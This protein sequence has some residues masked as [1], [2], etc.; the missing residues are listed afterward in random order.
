MILPPL[1]PSPAGHIG[2]HN[3][4]RTE[5][6]ANTTAR[7]RNIL[8]AGMETIPR[9]S[10]ISNTVQ[11]LG[12]NL[13][14]G[15]TTARRAETVTKVQMITGSTAAAATPTLIRAG[16]YYQE[17]NLSWTLVASTVSD[18]ALLATAATLYTK[19]LSAPL[20]LVEG[21]RYALGLLVVTAVAA[22]TMYGAILPTGLAALTPMLGANITG[23]ANLPA[24]ITNAAV[25]A[26]ANGNL[27]YIVAN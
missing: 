24:T 21:R 16:I 8:A 7:D 19:N 22:P 27:P 9:L 17:D 23:Q 12:S 10:A 11:T 1:V 26:G 15:L 25:I 20:N 18:T 6:N 4:E 5:I 14:L 3:A 13:R 2:A